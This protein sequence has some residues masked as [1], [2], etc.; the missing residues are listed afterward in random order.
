M[1]CGWEGNRRSGVELAVRHKIEV[2]DPPAQALSKGDEHPTTYTLLIVYGTG[3]LYLYIYSLV[4]SL[5]VLDL[6]AKTTHA[7][8][9]CAAVSHV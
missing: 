3:T 5:S 7:T 9:H 6:V 8:R 1:S 2:V 4:T